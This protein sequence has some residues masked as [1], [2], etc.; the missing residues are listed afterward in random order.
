MSVTAEKQN[1]RPRARSLPKRRAGPDAKSRPQV[2]ISRIGVVETYDDPDAG[3]GIELFA[4]S[5]L[6]SIWTDRPDLAPPNR[7]LVDPRY[8]VKTGW[9]LL[10]W[11]DGRY[12][13]ERATD[14]SD[15]RSSPG[16]IGVII[17]WFGEDV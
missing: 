6:G 17:G 11:R 12:L 4:V 13:V 5:G 14:S 2:V 15:G 16:F 1:K 8:T 3:G 7:L 9:H 10:Y